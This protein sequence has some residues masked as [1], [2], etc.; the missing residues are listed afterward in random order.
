MRTRDP[1]RLQE[2]IDGR[3][4][5]GCQHLHLG[6]GDGPSLDRGREVATGLTVVLA[7]GSDAWKLAAQNSVLRPAGYIVV[8]ASSIRDAID[9]FEA[10]DFDLVL[11]DHS[12]S[13]ESKERLSFLIQASG[14][15]TP[16]LSIADSPCDPRSFAD[17]TIKNDP[18]TML[19]GVG[20]LPAQRMKISLVRKPVRSNSRE[21]AVA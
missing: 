2:M 5:E 7:V 11:L 8:S 10:G 15:R 13:V 19:A 18:V 12:I 21:A 17:A 14:A 4:V 3:G 1:D 16:V 6:N 9:R 20:G